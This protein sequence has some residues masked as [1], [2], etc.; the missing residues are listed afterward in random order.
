MLTK[1]NEINSFLSTTEE[2]LQNISHTFHTKGWQE[3]LNQ[4]YND[5]N[6][7]KRIVTK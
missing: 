4:Q 3:I 1:F 5:K 2:N 6:M 7:K